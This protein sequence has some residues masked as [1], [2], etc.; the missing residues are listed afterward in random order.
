MSVYRVGSILDDKY[1]ILER[2]G[3][4]GMGEVF[5]VRHVHLHEQ[6]VIK[7][8]RQDRAADP[9]AIQRFSQEARIATQI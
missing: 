3:A 1:E 9:T 5:R 6:R 4:G 8:L 2:L 7:I